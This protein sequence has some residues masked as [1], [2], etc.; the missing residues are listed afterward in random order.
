[1][2]VFTSG[3]TKAAT[4]IPAANKAFFLLTLDCFFAIN[5]N[6]LRESALLRAIYSL[7]L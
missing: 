3:T 2:K 4:I 7:K 6:S 1:M 5:A